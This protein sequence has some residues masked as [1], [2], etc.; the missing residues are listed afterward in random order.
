MK[1]GIKNRKSDKT[2]FAPYEC[3]DDFLP[4]KNKCCEYSNTA[5]FSPAAH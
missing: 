3:K 1:L 5:L 2:G 4:G